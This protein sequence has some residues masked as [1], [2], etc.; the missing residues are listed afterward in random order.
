MDGVFDN[1]STFHPS[2]IIRKSLLT[3]ETRDSPGG[4]V[5]RPWLIDRETWCGSSPSNGQVH[6]SLARSY[7]IRC[8]IRRPVFD[9]FISE[10]GVFFL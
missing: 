5:V 6:E 9:H 7:F 4:L 2:R 10:G 3:L 8:F 1:R